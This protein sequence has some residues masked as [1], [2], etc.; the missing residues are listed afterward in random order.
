MNISR[1]EQRALRVLARGGRILHERGKHSKITA[2]PCSAGDGLILSDFDRT[3][4][5]RLR[6]KGLIESGLEAHIGSRN[7]AI[8]PVRPHLDNQ[9]GMTC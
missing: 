6:C 8:A 5:N 2:V 7:A 3:V 4:F 1:N 9:G